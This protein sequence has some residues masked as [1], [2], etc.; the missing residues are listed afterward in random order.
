MSFSSCFSVIR[1]TS[2][3]I[4]S[5]QNIYLETDLGILDIITEVTGVGDYH[6]I[7]KNAIKVPLFGQ[8]CLVISPEDLIKQKES[9]GRDKDRIV[10]RELRAILENKKKP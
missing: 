6:S 4:E 1:S 9:L 8:T 2:K 3:S 10:A 7:K 5:V